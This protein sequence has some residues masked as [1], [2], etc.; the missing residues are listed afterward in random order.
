[1]DMTVFKAVT[2]SAYLS[3]IHGTISSTNIFDGTIQFNTSLSPTVDSTSSYA[4]SGIWTQM[5][6]ATIA[7]YSLD[8]KTNTIK[9]KT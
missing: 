5:G 2:Y 3:Q 4:Q 8:H 9:I 6:Q 7:G 1:M